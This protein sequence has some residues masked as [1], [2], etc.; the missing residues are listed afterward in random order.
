MKAA[1]IE[2]SQR[3]Q[4]IEA[5]EPQ[6]GAHQVRVRLEGC[7]VCASNFPVWKGGRGSGIP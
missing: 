5:E 2:E 4:I 3:L 1:V 7:G 6:P